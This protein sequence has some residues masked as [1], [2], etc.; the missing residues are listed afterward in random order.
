MAAA[1]RLV[2]GPAKKGE[3]VG[4]PPIRHQPDILPVSGG[5]GVGRDRWHPLHGGRLRRHHVEARQTGA[6]AHVESA[7][8]V[9]VAIAAWMLD[10]V[11]CVGMEPGPP[12][13]SISASAGRHDLLA[14]RGSARSSSGGATVAKE[15][16]HDRPEE[17]D[18]VRAAPPADDC[19]RPEAAARD[20][21]CG[22]PD[23]SDDTRDPSDRGHGARD[24]RRR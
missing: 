16:P 3:E 13:V 21:R 8:G 2:S 14:Q 17:T 4:L 10:P 12:R 22:T 1:R 24:G 9:V 18:A 7:A 23:G 6:L 5:D 11:A 20:G 19:V 15:E